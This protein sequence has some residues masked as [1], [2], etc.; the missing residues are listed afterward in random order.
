MAIK[1]P[2]ST[3][4]SANTTGYTTEQ[5][6]RNQAARRNAAQQ[7]SQAKTAQYEAEKAQKRREKTE[8]AEELTF[9][10]V[11]WKLAIYACVIMVVI[12]LLFANINGGSK[13]IGQKD[14]NTTP[15]PPVATVDPNAVPD[16]ANTDGAA[17]PD[18]GTD[19]AAETP[20]P[21][22]TNTGDASGSTVIQGLSGQT[23]NS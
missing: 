22:I 1:R 4:Q 2:Q 11:M 8:T 17:A 21:D 20:T 6:K 14:T 10:N 3:G 15:T 5:Q 23:A 12:S 16:D 19:Q 18:A 7:R 9:S 13:Y